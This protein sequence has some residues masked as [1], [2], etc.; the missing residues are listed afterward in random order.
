MRNVKTDTPCVCSQKMKT[1]YAIIELNYYVLSVN[2]TM[3]TTLQYELNCCTVLVSVLRTGFRCWQEGCWTLLDKTG[4]RSMV[5]EQHLHSAMRQRTNVFGE[6]TVYPL[7]FLT[8]RLYGM[9][10]ISK[11]VVVGIYVSMVY[12]SVVIMS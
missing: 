3:V 7:H 9:E 1:M 12:F 8:F 11:F 4:D 5:F 10:S 2:I 6:V